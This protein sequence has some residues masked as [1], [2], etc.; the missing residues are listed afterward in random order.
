[1]IVTALLLGASASALTPP[2]GLQFGFYRMAA[3]RQRVIESGC[4]ADLDTL[5]DLRR[6]LA[7]RFGKRAFTW[8][9]VPTSAPGDCSA[10]SSVYTVNLADFRK[11]A[12]VALAI[13]GAPKPD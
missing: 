5:E 10:V 12:A 11:E 9:N 13:P 4:S 3:F 2:P 8:P 1:M 7:E 6:R